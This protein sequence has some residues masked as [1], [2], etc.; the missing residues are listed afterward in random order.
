MLELLH[1]VEVAPV[2]TT[3]N[4]RVG[5]RVLDDDGIVISQ[6]IHGESGV[7]HAEVIALSRAGDKA[8]GATL[9]ITLEP[10]NHIG[11]TGPCSQAI[12]DAGIAR[13][14]F[15]SA[16]TTKAAGGADF[17]TQQGVDVV[18][19]VCSA[20]GDH[21]VAPWKH[22]N[23]TGLPFVTLKLAT[24]L[25]G[26]VAA[27]DSSSRWITGEVAR[28]FVHQLRASVDAIAV[29]SSTVAVDDPLLDV[30]LP[31]QWPQPQRYIVGKRDLAANF[32]LNGLATQIKSH[33]PKEV[34]DFMA[35]TGVQHVLLEG[36]PTV[37]AAF[38]RAGLVN[39]IYWCIAP[40]VLGAGISAL[41]GL[42]ISAITDAIQWRI[43]KSWQA[44][45]DV[46]IELAV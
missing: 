41:A 1:D 15:A 16:D 2:H 8:R 12:L 17:L 24:T 31:G 23:Q 34:L 9:L 45:D 44:G 32:R 18:G 30:R 26:Y 7:D 19:G 27:T 25:D 3:P 6:G 13:V 29:G 4:P 36:G 28:T 40:K 5:A 14:V 42:G 20:E 39:R 22:F 46:I 43:V 37:A 10:C 33:D 38:V 35:A 11:K 21:L